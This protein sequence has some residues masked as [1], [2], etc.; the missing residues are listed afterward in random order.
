MMLGT[1]DMVPGFIP[2]RTMRAGT[3]L[4]VFVDE[5]CLDIGEVLDVLRRPWDSRIRFV[6]RATSFVRR[7]DRTI[8]AHSIELILS[9]PRDA[10]HCPN[11]GEHPEKEVLPTL[12][13]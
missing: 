7:K 1:S 6:V 9:E 8:T 3:V 10:V 2:S 5:F 11:D 13:V 12:W 4:Q